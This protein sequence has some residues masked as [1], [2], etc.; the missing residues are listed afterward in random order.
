MYAFAKLTR[1]LF[2]I[3]VLVQCAATINAQTTFTLLQCPQIC[4]KDKAEFNQKNQHC[5]SDDA[6][7]QVLRAQFAGCTQ[8]TVRYCVQRSKDQLETYVWPI[9]GEI[10]RINMVSLSSKGIDKNILESQ[11]D[12]K[13]YFEDTVALCEQIKIKIRLQNL[14]LKRDGYYFKNAI[15]NEVYEIP[16][17]RDSL[18]ITPDIFPADKRD[19]QLT[20][21]NTSK[22]EKQLA[23]F[24]LHILSE[25]EK[26]DVQDIVTALKTTYPDASDQKITDIS[27]YLLDPTTGQLKLSDVQYLKN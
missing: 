18:I 19:L 6:Y 20:L 11:S 15:T 14:N 22:P 4:L 1:Y 16:A 12:I 9:G 27:N 2:V 5:A 3:F 13:H 10:V 25:E 21:F 8:G 26:S 7:Q 24:D 17:I 23:A